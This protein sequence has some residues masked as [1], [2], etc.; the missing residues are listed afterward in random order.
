MSIYSGNKRLQI[1]AALA[2]GTGSIGPCVPA[3]DGGGTPSGAG[4]DEDRNLVFKDASGAALF[5][6]NLSNLAF[7]T[8]VESQPNMG[9]TIDGNGALIPETNMVVSGFT[10][11]PKYMYSHICEGNVPVENV[12]FSD[13]TGVSKAYSFY[14]FAN[15]NTNIKSVKFPKLKTISGIN[16]MEYAFNNCTNLTSIVLSSLEQIT[17]DYAFRYTFKGC[18][19]LADCNLQNLTDINGTYNAC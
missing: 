3:G 18:S 1:F 5:S 10:D 6:A 17:N 2:N 7:V 13:L 9:Y 14:Y 15:G 19:K 11:I 12:E 16:G 4:M 8:L